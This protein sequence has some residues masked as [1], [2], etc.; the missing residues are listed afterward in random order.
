MFESAFHINP[1]VAIESAWLELENAGCDL[2]Y[3]NEEAN[4]TQVIFGYLPA[5]VDEKTL[6]AQHPFILE[7]SQASFGTIDWTSQWEAHGPSFHDGYIHV[8]LNSYCNSFTPTS[9][10]SIIRLAPGPGFGD[11]SHPTTRLVLQLMSQHVK[12]KDVIDMGCGSG[13]LSLAA[14]AMG[15]QSVL[16]V[17]IDENA[18]TH[19]R[20]NSSTNNMNEHIEF[21]NPQ[22]FICKIEKISENNQVLLMN[23]I[24]TEQF[25][26]W[27]SLPS[28]HSTVRTIIT[29][30]ILK[31]GKKSYLK[32]T[33]SWGW[34]IEQEL[35]EDG[36]MGFIFTN[37]P[38]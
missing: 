15:A 27:T 24:E 2:L 37:K 19:A 10:H 4:G 34:S 9:S 31:T 35:E 33:K 22:N 18:L 30:G 7:I 38:K 21:F 28:I 20:A 32:L 13:I 16:G 1:S 29:S 23:M 14:H 5:H 11:L 12:N 26:V 3:S 6:I 8:D 36:W 17:D 25:Q